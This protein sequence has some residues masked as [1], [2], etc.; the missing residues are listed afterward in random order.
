MP[1]VLVVVHADQPRAVLIVKA[2]REEGVVGDIG[3]HNREARDG[4]DGVEGLE[5]LALG[6][7]E[8]RRERG[9]VE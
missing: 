9:R 1:V 6:K 4:D 5:L 8:A 7:V 3:H 2:T